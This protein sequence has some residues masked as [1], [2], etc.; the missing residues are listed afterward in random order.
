M[1][2]FFGGLCGIRGPPIIIFFLHLTCPKAVQKGTGAAITF[3][4]VSMRV[5]YYAIDS[6][7]SQTLFHADKWPLYLGVCLSSPI[8]VWVG[9][10]LFDRMKDSQAMMKT[11]LAFLLVLC[12]ISLIISAWF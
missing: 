11:I 10:K 1:S 2:G 5:I 4:N 9:G 7:Q 3:V 12:G 8:G 6:T